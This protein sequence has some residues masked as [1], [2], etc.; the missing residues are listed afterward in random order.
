[1]PLPLLLPVLLAA[2]AAP[3]PVPAQ[4]AF[5]AAYEAMRAGRLPEALDRYAEALA[6]APASWDISL[7]YTSALR[8]AGELQKAVRAGWRT[9]ELGPDRAASWNNLSNVLQ[10]ANALPEALQVAEE[11]ARRF[12]RDANTVKAFTNLGYTAWTLLDFPLA[13]RSLARAVE[14]APTHRVARVDLAAARLSAGRPGGLAEL[15]AALAEAKR[16]ADGPATQW[17]EHLLATA[18]SHPEGLVPPYPRTW[19]AEGLPPAL[20]VR[21][22]PGKAASLPIGDPRSRDHLLQRKGTLRLAMPEGWRESREGSKAE[23]GLLNLSYEPSKGEPF[24]V[25]VTAL[26][27]P[28]EPRPLTPDLARGILSARLS[29]PGVQVHWLPDPRG[30]LAWA[31]DPAWKP[32]KPGDFPHVLT[33]LVAVGPAW[34]TVSAFWGESAGEPPKAFLDLVTSLAWTPARSR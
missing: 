1:M 4:K 34:V 11:M 16:E 14:L 13:E 32:G 21:P 5:D 9:V 20:R 25:K 31:R 24:L 12:P 3:L 33:A 28:G 29:Q 7:E 22:E 17:A 6:L 26:M 18:R 2:Q 23:E 15:E 30:A 8:Q 10:T 19:A 27:P